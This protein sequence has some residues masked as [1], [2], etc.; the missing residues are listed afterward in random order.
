MGRW[1]GWVRWGAL[2][3]AVVV[4][5][6]FLVAQRQSI[7][8]SYGRS[9]SSSGTVEEGSAG[10][11]SDATVP[12]V[13]EMTAMVAADPVVRLPGSIAHWDEGLVRKAIGDADVRVL[14][15]PPGLDKDERGRV[16]DVDNAQLRVLGTEVTGS[17]YQASADDLPS[18]RA[19]FATG[20]VT[21]QL[22]TLIAEIREQDA[23]ED[24]DVFRWRPPTEA[25]VTAVATDLRATGVHV[26]D[27]ATLTDIPKAAGPAFPDG[28]ALYAAFPQ[29]TFGEPVPEYGP[30]LAALFPDRPIVV[31][32]GS[33]IEYHGPNAAD[34]TDVVGASF[35]GQ[36]A[37]RISTYAYPQGNVLHAY[38]NR[39]T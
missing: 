29:Q 2:G 1:A 30:T 31:I 37:D 4:L 19:Q 34:F 3:A 26:A 15:A 13:D 32:Y 6:V 35:Y 22:V 7:D 20:D 8:V 21:N 16:R 27:G 38:L 36:A 18:W 23:P 17:I 5:V 12:S 9:P 39:V 24:V 10:E 25:E 33:W 14:V 11:L 28:G